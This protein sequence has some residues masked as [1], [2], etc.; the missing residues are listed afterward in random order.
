LENEII[1]RKAEEIFPSLRRLAHHLR[2][3]S[4]HKHER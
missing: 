4:L 1:L 3:F 2:G